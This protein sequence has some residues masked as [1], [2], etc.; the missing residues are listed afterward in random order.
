MQHCVAFARQQRIDAYAAFSRYLLEAA[1]FDLMRDKH[2]ALLRGQLPERKLELLEQ[3]AAGVKGFRSGVGRWQQVFQSQQ[4]SFL[5]SGDG[6]I[7]KALRFLPAEEISDAVA[8]DTEK[9]AG[10]MLD[11][12]Q[13]AIRLY[14]FVEDLL[15]NVFGIARIRH[16][17]TN[18]IVQPGLLPLDHLGDPL[19][20]FRAHLFEAQ[21]SQARRAI[22]LGCRRFGG[23]EYC[24]A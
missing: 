10:Y 11:W 2:F 24:R 1:P 19:I 13:Q 3:H 6:G 7:R 9:P 21:P 14:Q 12:H 18:E 22:H 23:S 8:R 17:W 20:L 15:Q 4:L 16:P 5:L